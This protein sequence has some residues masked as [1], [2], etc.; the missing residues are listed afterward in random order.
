MTP[1]RDNEDEGELRMGDS[2]TFVLS[3]MYMGKSTHSHRP[4]QA[5]TE[6]L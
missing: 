6:D 2:Q 3:C 5:H 4:P 1:M